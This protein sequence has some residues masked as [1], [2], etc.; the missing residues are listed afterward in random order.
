MVETTERAQCSLFR[1]ACE[2]LFFDA[3]P[4]GHPFSGL[5]QVD[6]FVI[7]PSPQSQISYRA[8]ATMQFLLFTAAL[9]GSAE[10]QHDESTCSN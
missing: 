2:L 9:R 4:D 1:T 8:K 10:P 6:G 7:L 5:R 3:V